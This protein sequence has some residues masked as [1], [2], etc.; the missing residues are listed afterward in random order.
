[1]QIALQQRELNPRAQTT[2]IDIGSIPSK[3][4]VLPA[5][6]FIAKRSIPGEFPGSELKIVMDN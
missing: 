2:A 1:M 6:F 4:T 3:L 5:I